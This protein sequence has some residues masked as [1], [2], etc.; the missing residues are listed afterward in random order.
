M[1]GKDLTISVLKHIGHA[2]P[3]GIVGAEVG[4]QGDARVELRQVVDAVVVAVQQRVLGPA[5]VQ[6]VVLLDAV[7]DVIAVCVGEIDKLPVGVAVVAETL[8]ADGVGVHRAGAEDVH[9]L[10]VR[11]AVVVGVHIT[12]ARA[13]ES[14]RVGVE[15]VTIAV[16]RWWRAVGGIIEEV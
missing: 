15:S 16:R 1:L 12:V 9:L 7:G 2:V 3:I 10:A 6:A 5:G 4:I 11:K 8:L 14:F 13:P